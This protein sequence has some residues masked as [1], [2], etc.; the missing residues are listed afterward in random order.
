MKKDIGVIPAVYPMPVLMVA[1]YDKAEKVNVMNVAW[2]QICDE[3]KIILF[4]GEGKR[5]WLNIKESGAFTVSIADRAHMDV[6]DFFGIASG[7][8]ISDKFE[9]TGYHAEKS[10][11][12]HAPVIEEFPLAMECELLDILDTEY[13]SGIV[14][15]IVNVRAEESVLDEKGKVDPARLDALIFDQFQSGY[16]VTGERVGRAWNA[17]AALM[18]KKRG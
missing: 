3:D 5:T 12:V 6:A 16:Y 15:R 9:R 14:G 2:G 8:K 4:I 17:G 7:N 11:R 10:E 13:V 18:G 1:A